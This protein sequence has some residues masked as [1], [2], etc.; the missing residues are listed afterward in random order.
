M[1]VSCESGARPASGLVSFR[2]VVVTEISVIAVL[3]DPVRRRL[4]DYVTAQDHG[5]S[6]SEA[7]A[8]TGIG[9]TLAAFHLDRLAEAGLVEVT[10]ARLGRA[11]RPRA[12]ARQAVPAGD[13]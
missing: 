11:V 12:G 9:R 13:G 6:R 5:V 8:A 7:A 10:F 1:W 4:Y 2:I 3:E